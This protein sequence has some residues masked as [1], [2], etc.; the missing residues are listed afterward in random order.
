MSEQTSDQLL[1]DLVA[2]A[3]VIPVCTA[4]GMVVSQW[5]T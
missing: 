5:L 2:A 1:R 4:I 3:A